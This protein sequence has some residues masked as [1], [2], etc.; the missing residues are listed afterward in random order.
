MKIHLLVIDGQKDFCTPGLTDQEIKAIEPIN[1]YLAKIL[2][3]QRGALYVPGANEDMMRVAAMIKR[4][5]SKLDDIH[6]TLDSHHLIDIAHPIFW[7]DSSTGQHP[8][9]FTIITAAEVAN[10]KYTTT[11]PRFMK[12]AVDYVNSL[13]T[14]GRYPLCIWP[15]HT[16]IGTWGYSLHTYLAEAVLEWEQ[17]NFAMANMVTKGSNFWTEHYS[18]VQ[19]DVPDPSDP[20]TMLNTDFINMLQEADEIA[21]AGEALSHCVYNTMKDIFDNFGEDN[22]KKFT[23]LK[24]CS[25]PVPGFEHLGDQFFQEMTARGMKV[26]KSTDYFI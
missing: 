5:G 21:V 18:A 25:S 23:F 9:P 1:P 8:A 22:I 15:P 13:E 11:N 17:K 7:L 12:R 6:L 26:A 16:I 19:A 2:A 4:L 3:Q 10:G 14:N 24:D 20:S